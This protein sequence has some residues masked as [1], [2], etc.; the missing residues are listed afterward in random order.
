MTLPS[1][2]QPTLYWHVFGAPLADTKGAAK[3][4]P[5][6]TY[7]PVAK[8]ADDQL[9]A[10]TFPGTDGETFRYLGSFDRDPS[11]EDLRGLRPETYK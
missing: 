11:D 9:R 7:G 10:M 3:N 1:S 5:Q 8:D 4:F 2:A 6:I